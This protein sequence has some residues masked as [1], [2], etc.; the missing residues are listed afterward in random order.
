MERIHD[1][2]MD[3]LAVRWF[4]D[5]AVKI[6]TK[7]TGYPTSA[8]PCMM[9]GP[10]DALFQQG[11]SSQRRPWE[12]FEEIT[13][14]E[15]PFKDGQ[16]SKKRR[17]IREWIRM[18]DTELGAITQRLAN[19]WAKAGKL[20]TNR[21]Y[22]GMKSLA[23]HFAEDIVLPESGA[24]SQEEIPIFAPSMPRPNTSSYSSP[25]PHTFDDNGDLVRG[26]YGDRADP[27]IQGVPEDLDRKANS[28]G[29]DREGPCYFKDGDATD[30]GPS[31]GMNALPTLEPS[32]EDIWRKYLTSKVLP[33]YEKLQSN[34]PSD[35]SSR[36]SEYE[37]LQSLINS[38]IL[39]PFDKVNKYVNLVPTR[40]MMDLVTQAEEMRSKLRDARKSCR[41]Q[42]DS[43][44]K[45]EEQRV[46]NSHLRNDAID[47]AK[48]KRPAGKLY[49]DMVLHQFKDSSRV[50]RR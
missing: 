32:L 36:I 1:I 44:Q 3:F 15:S 20:T 29:R 35:L 37:R 49:V 31:I 5:S 11:L 39:F 4:A 21:H 6:L 43:E 18:F 47:R 22:N 42:F 48:G 14:S 8:F 46:E 10:N 2:E 28:R 17:L 16:T 13:S 41:S 34:P 30:A 27:G 12:Q 33:Q 25:H 23:L 50:L 38:K 19:A 9:A 24:E 40:Q 45:A 26:P 7:L